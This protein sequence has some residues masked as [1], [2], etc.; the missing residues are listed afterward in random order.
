VSDQQ[1]LTV[2]EWVAK[3]LEELYPTITEDTWDDLRVLLNQEPG[4][5]A[6]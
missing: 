5:Q 3:Q 2:D 1:K 4:N 6:A